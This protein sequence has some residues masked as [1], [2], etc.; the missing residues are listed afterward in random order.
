MIKKLLPWSRKN[1][2]DTN[3]FGEPLTGAIVGN[4]DIGCETVH[5][6]ERDIRAEYV[7]HTLVK[8]FKGV[9]IHL[10]TQYNPYS[11]TTRSS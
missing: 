9:R 11:W 1:G 10:T 2:N 7:P 3:S 5:E 8:Y 6:G 4:E